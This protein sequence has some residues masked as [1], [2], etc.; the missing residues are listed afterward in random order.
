MCPVTREELVPELL[1]QRDAVREHVSRQQPFEEVVVAAVAV[2]PRQTE[3]AGD[4]VRLEHRPN[5]VRR[6]TEPVG[7]PTLRALEV[8]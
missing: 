4:G 7:R 8:E 2:P 3:D 1:R 6:D 5:G